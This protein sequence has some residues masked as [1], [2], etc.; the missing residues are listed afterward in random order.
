MS[1]TTSQILVGRPHPY[2][3]GMNPE[4]ALYLHEGDNCRWSMHKINLADSQLAR[5][6]VWICD[7]NQIMADALLLAAFHAGGDQTFR[8]HLLK[9]F[10][11][12]RK[13]ML[14]SAEIAHVDR[15]E[16]L[17][18]IRGIKMP[19]L[20]VSVFE[21]SSLDQKQTGLLRDFQF[22]CEICEPV[23]YRLGSVW[24]TATRV[25]GELPG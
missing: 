21:G 5:L 8:D 3:G 4:F 7:P 14:E 6:S 23:S 16:M 22:D 18:M 2:E 24:K 17:D 10:P 13:E 25:G 11:A 20:V 1:A 19:K 15:L 9:V 12:A